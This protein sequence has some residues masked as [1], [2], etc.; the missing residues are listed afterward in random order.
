[1]IIATSRKQFLASYFIIHNCPKV[2]TARARKLYWSLKIQYG[3]F[4]S[5]LLTSTITELKVQYKVHTIVK[6]CTSSSCSTRIWVQTISFGRDAVTEVWAFDRGPRFYLR[7]RSVLV[8]EYRSL[9]P[10]SVPGN[11]DI[12]PPDIAV[13]TDKFRYRYTCRYTG[14]S[15]C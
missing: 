12:F 7:P 8:P 14:Y 15:C 13:H 11:F 9:V 2:V 1:M 6:W 4:R 5:I 3:V 10:L